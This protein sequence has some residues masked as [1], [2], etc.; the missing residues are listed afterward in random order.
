[1]FTAFAIVVSN[2]LQVDM[3]VCEQVFSWLYK[4]KRIT[5]KMNQHTF[6]FVFYYFFLCCIFVTSII[7]TSSRNWS[8]WILCTNFNKQLYKLYINVMFILGY[9]Y[10][11]NN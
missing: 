2:M 11:Q 1:M 5:Q 4:Y 7:Y 3:E 8:E 6:M 9:F 10:V